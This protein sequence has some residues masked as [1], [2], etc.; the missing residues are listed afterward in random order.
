MPYEETRER[1][2][3]ERRSA[4]REN[5]VAYFLQVSLAWGNSRKCFDR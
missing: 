1:T 2:E 4:A 5:M 3:E